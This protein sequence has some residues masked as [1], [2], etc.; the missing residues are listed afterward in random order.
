MI[1]VSKGMEKESL[2]AGTAVLW[3][4]F[5]FAV[6]LF[7]TFLDVAVWRKVFPG[8]SDWLNVITIC[9]CV[10]GFVWLLIKKTFFRLELL[11]NVTVK[12]IVLAI[13]CSFAFYVVL[14]N[15]LDPVFERAFPASEQIYLESAQALMASPVTSFVQVCIIAPAIEEILMRG[16]VLKG[17]KDTYG[18]AVGL[19]TSALLFAVLHFNMVQTLSAFIC[20]LVLG[21]LFI[22]TKSVLCCMAAHGGYNLISYMVLLHQFY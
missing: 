1:C 8:F 19:I 10:S 15:F 9:L 7:Y 12:G 14:D 20:G 4:A 11:A 21:I 17:L 16:F 6:M 3:V 5:Y 13:G 22:S 18:T 2:K